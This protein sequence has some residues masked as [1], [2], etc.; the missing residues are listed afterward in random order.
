MEKDVV[1][2]EA[3]MEKA[4][5]PK[6]SSEEFVRKEFSFETE[7]SSSCHGWHNPRRRFCRE[8]IVEGGL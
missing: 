1:K 5:T 8:G 3:V 4:L 6:S 2:E 7:E